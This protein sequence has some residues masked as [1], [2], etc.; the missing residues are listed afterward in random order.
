[1]G[2]LRKK[3]DNEKVDR[4]LGNHTLSK[5]NIQDRYNLNKDTAKNLIDNGLYQ[6]VLNNLKSFIPV[7]LPAIAVLLVENGRGYSVLNQIYEFG[8]HLDQQDIA[9]LI[10]EQQGG[11]YLV[12]RLKDLKGVDHAPVVDR[13][14]DSNFPEIAPE[15]MDLFV[16]VDHNEVAKKLIKLGNTFLLAENLANFEGLDDEVA[17]ALINE[18]FDYAVR[19]NFNAFTDLNKVQLFHV[20]AHGNSNGFSALRYIDPSQDIGE[21]VVVFVGDSLRFKGNP[22]TVI[23]ELN[24]VCVEHGN[25]GVNRVSDKTPAANGR[26]AQTSI[27]FLKDAFAEPIP[28]STSPKGMDD[29]TESM[30][31]PVIR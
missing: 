10:A 7:D 19:D 28:E 11:R 12:H 29:T 4:L 26:Y 14:L 8:D 20:G 25:V 6:M 24:V 22:E 13:I 2:I 31:V 23:A 21:Q 1:M 9:N 16:N 3:D 27:A 18:G 5:L 17:L 15:N 30:V